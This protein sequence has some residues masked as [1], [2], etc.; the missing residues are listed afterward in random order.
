MRVGHDLHS[1]IVSDHFFTWCKSGKVKEAEE[2]MFLIKDALLRSGENQVLVDNELLI[3]RNQHLCCP[4]NF[5]N[6][7]NTPELFV[8]NFK[9]L[10]QIKDKVLFENQNFNIDIDDC[11]DIVH[12]IQKF[13]ADISQPLTDS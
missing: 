13:V 10:F 6:V 2:E 5:W 8:Q 1:L 3:E 4:E 9:V 11:H 7:C 12:K